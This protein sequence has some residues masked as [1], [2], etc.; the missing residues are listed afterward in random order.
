MKKK[1]K[2]ETP[3]IEAKTN[4]LEGIPFWF[5]DIPLGV[6]I[7]IHGHWFEIVAKGIKG[8]T[9]EHRRPTNRPAGDKNG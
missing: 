8:L 9:L 2:K 6:Q 5:G 1:K 7:P 4:E 3:K